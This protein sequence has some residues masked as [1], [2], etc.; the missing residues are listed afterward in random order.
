MKR[1]EV[2]L[3]IQLAFV[4]G[5]ITTHGLYERS[6]AKRIPAQCFSADDK[7][8]VAG[9]LHKE[10]MRRRERE[11]PLTVGALLHC[12]RRCRN[13]RLPEMSSLLAIPPNLYR[14]ME[15]DR[16]SPLKCS[17]ETWRRIRD[18]CRI[19]GNELEHLIR[20]THQ[21]VLYRASFRTTLARYDGRRN[22]KQRSDVLERAAEE[23][24]ARADLPIP[25]R[26]EER[27]ESLLRAISQEKSLTPER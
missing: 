23:L 26:V 10:V 20:R 9:E 11:P 27:L 12:L 13:L 6:V 8:R 25:F 3:M 16:I 4:E 7:T 19:P 15:R 5:K 1:D 24:Y 22:K 14:M 17:P 2:D 18:L 21:L